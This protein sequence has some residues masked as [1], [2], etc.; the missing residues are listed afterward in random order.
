MYRSWLFFICTKCHQPDEGVA[1][2]PEFWSDTFPYPLCPTYRKFSRIISILLIGLLCWGILYIIAGN[3]AAPGGHLFDIAVL[4]I[5]AYLGGWIFSLTTLPSLIGML[6]T[7]IALQNLNLVDIND[8]FD[9]IVSWFRKIALTIIL[10]RAGLEM[11]PVL[12]KKIK[13]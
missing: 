1:W 8:D 13:G 5:S 4:S 10:I 12:F 6:F 9:D 11:D 7:G 3:V 2:E